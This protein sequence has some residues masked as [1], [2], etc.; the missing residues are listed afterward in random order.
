MLPALFPTTTIDAHAYLW[1]TR[2]PS[3]HGEM[4]VKHKSLLSLCAF[5]I[6]LAP[7]SVFAQ[8]APS[9]PAPV[10]GQPPPAAPPNVSP[11]PDQA[12]PTPVQEKPAA[13]PL[14]WRGTSFTW[15][16][17]ATSTML[18]IGRDNIGAEDDSYSWDF[19][20]S[21][22]IYLLDLPNDK[23][24]AF[25]EGGVSVEW[26]DSGTT[27]YKHEPQFRDTQIGVGYN[28]NI[29][30]TDDGE[31]ATSA[32]VR[33]RY[34][35]PTSKFSLDQGRYGVLSLGV[36]ATQKIR[37]LGD[38]A[39]GLNNLSVI[40]G[41]T[42]S[43]LFARSYTP[44][45]SDLERTRQ[46]ASG[47]SISSDQLSFRSMDID[48]LIPSA[49]FIL[50]LYKDLSLT[51]QFRLVGRFRHEFEG[52]DCEVVVMG[53]C[54]RADRLDNAVTYLTDSTFDIA[55]SQPIYDIL[56]INLGYNNETLT[57]G[58]DGKSRNIFYSPSAQFY[59][60][61]VANIDVMYQ[62]ASG[63]S[64]FDLPPGPRNTITATNQYGM[65]A[66]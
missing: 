17:S 18:G 31:W 57:L 12:S 48:R 5:G 39:A 22:Q 11:P 55:L 35:I 62:K 60:D 29:F 50:P 47:A 58:E 42:W 41:L 61:L 53:E 51:T 66:F 15:S 54:Q 46:N 14:I 4:T 24:F 2:L 28:R 52:N 49:T 34:N 9:D 27:T 13:D 10:V 6:A 37:L 32:G 1:D 8:A 33:A 3:T 56:Q 23:I 36:S 63:Q 64:S 38:K 25:A 26:T 65:P 44:T 59:L 7:L 45:N 19:I 21:P 20:L 30:T 43:H 40:A 16:Q